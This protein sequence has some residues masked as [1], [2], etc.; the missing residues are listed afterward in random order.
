MNSI[1]YGTMHCKK[2][3]SY[4]KTTNPLI[5]KSNSKASRD[6]KLY[7]RISLKGVCVDCKSN[8]SRFLSNNEVTLLPQ[9]IK[10]IPL[11]SS[12]GAGI[13]EEVLPYLLKLPINQLPIITKGSGL[14]DNSIL[15]SLNL[16]NAAD[17]IN[18]INSLPII[19]NLNNV[20]QGEG[21]IED[22]AR[23]A[24]KWG[25][26]QI[27]LVGDLLADSGIVDT[28]A[29]WFGDNIWNPLKK[30]F[31]GSGIEIDDDLIKKVMSDPNFSNNFANI[32]QGNNGKIRD[33]I[34]SLNNGNIEEK[35][36]ADIISKTLLKSNFHQFIKGNGISNETLLPEAV[37][38]YIKRKKTYRNKT[39]KAI[40]MLKGNGV[41]VIEI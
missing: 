33:Y 27:P 15:T 25:V 19:G 24:V 6:G 41:E 29:D 40:E 17:A 21:I 11:N 36:L 38:K 31:G 8:K 12:A 3:R 9:T 20:T 4:T 1:E 26:R 28:A 14:G 16:N 18:S 34:N 2:C 39:E 7:D 30:A 13:I 32:L 35:T 23:K 22:T 5:N 37:R 10:D